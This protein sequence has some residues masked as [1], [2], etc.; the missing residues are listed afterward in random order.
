MPLWT[1]IISN[2]FYR[3]VNVLSALEKSLYQCRHN[4]R[5][6]YSSEL[7][8]IP[9]FAFVLLKPHNLEAFHL[10][11]TPVLLIL[12]VDMKKKWIKQVKPYSLPKHKHILKSD[13]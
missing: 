12:Y 6:V 2:V 8:Q 11:S 10:K 3:D 9:W 13:Y 5:L 4:S 7:L 1:E